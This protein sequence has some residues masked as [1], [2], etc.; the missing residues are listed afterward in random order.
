MGGLVVDPDTHETDVIGLFA[1]GEC[2]AGL[3]GANRLGGNSLTETI[4]YGRRAGEAA[5][6]YALGNDVALRPQRVIREANDRIAAL[7]RNGTE[8]A[9]AAQR[10]LR[11]L[12]WEHGGVVR[13]DEGLRKGLSRLEA[14]RGALDQID[15]RPTEEGWSDLA[16]AMDLRAGIALAE[17]TLQSA[18]VRTETRGCHN[19]SDFPDLD[20]DLQVNFQTRLDGDDRAVAPVPV[21]VPPVPVEL[22][23][24]LTQRW[25]VELA[26]RLLE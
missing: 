6:A 23:P 5:A 17:V 21:P 13:S 2:T 25:D 7:V 14:V 8:L 22:E 24:W 9:R 18:L 12:L 20:A 1:A 15:V 19:R 10:E 16:Q 4:V 26:G 11:D 3:H